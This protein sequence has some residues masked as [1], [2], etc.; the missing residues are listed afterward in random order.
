[1]IQIILNNFYLQKSKIGKYLNTK[2]LSIFLAITFLLFVVVFGNQFVLTVKESAE[3][4]VPFKELLPIVSLNMLRDIPL[5]VTLSLFLAIILSISQLYKNSEAVVMNSIG[6]GRK[7]FTVIIQPIVFVTFFTMLVFTTYVIPTAKYEKNIIENKAENS[8]EF[9]FITEGE[10]EDFK[11]GEIVFFASNSKSIDDELVQNMEEIFIYAL[12]NEEPIIIVASEAQK[13]LN[14]E[15][16]GTYLRLKNG[17]RYQGFPNSKN[18]KI[19]EFD[20][21]DL[22]IVSGETKDAINVSRTIESL[23]TQQLLSDGSN[24]ALAEFQWRLSQPI[25]L[26]ILSFIGVLLGK[27]SPRSSKGLG[28]IFGVGIFIIYNNC[29]LITKSAIEN[30]ALNPFLGLFGVHIVVI[31]IFFLTYRLTELNSYNFI[32]KISFFNPLKK[33][34]HV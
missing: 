26:L 29:L 28:L 22:E 8:S 9:S 7:H 18:K 2:L 25:S 24:L 19:L 5:I 4:G 15:N 30:G 33:N 20:L 6:L 32:D 23:K 16:Q 34:N 3:I 14:S 12:S 10:F 1:M 27:T 31:I 13:Y 21:Y 11:N 17:V